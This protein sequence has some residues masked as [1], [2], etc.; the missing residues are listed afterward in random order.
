[1]EHLF[2]CESEIVPAD[3]SRQSL[4]GGKVP[5]NIRSPVWVSRRIPPR[6]PFLMALKQHR[7]EAC[8][9]RIIAETAIGRARS[10]DGFMMGGFLADLPRDM[11]DDVELHKV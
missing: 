3:S 11:R 9:G 7:D 2:P 6:V 10:G 4:T 1:M 8:C 5:P